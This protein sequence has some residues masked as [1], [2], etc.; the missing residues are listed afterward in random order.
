MFIDTP[1][2][3]VATLESRWRDIRAE[4]EALPGQSFE[5]WVQREMYGTGWSVY[6]LIAFG[7]PIDAALA[8]CPATA[9]ALA[10]VPHLTTAG[11]SRLAP[12][13]W[14]KPHVGWVTT[15]YRAHLG[16]IVPEHCALRVGGQ[17]RPWREGSTLIFDDTSVH[18]AWNR[19]THT[20][21][22][23]LF[24]FMRPGCEGLPADEPPAEVRALIERHTGNRS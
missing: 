22:V 20:R 15:V 2:E 24:D 6:G 9:A 18:E 19:S 3:F 10:A 13:A 16:L 7:A 21:T 1:F 11:F 23:L 5:P 8:S 14:I 12:G 4:C 17:T